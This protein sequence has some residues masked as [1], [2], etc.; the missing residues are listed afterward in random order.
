MAH[1]KFSDISDDADQLMDLSSCQ[2]CEAGH[3]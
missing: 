2:D 1:L 3:V